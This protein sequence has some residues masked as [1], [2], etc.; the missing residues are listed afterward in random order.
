MKRSTISIPYAIAGAAIPLIPL[1]ILALVLL[2]AKPAGAHDAKPTA[3]QPL[4]WAY[5]YSCC[6]VNDCR[7]VKDSAVSEDSRG[8]TIV[9]TGELIPYGDRRIK[10]SKDEFF[11]LCTVAGREDGKA[12]CVYVPNRGI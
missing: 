11:H 3:T 2:A 9:A 4:G 1:I 10:Q 5:D 6:S 8:F 12:L 7:E